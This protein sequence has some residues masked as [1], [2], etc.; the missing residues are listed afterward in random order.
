M[1][2]LW[3]Q[4]YTEIGPVLEVKTFCHLDVHGIEVQIP[5]TSGNNTNVWVVM[6]RGQK[7]YVNELRHKESE[8]SP[9]IIELTD[10]GDIQAT[11]VIPPTTQS[12]LQRFRGQ[13]D[14]RKSTC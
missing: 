11:D 9:R 1:V 13:E 10:Y 2:K 5:S 6:S 14:L 3:I 4:K 12:R 8:R 7:R